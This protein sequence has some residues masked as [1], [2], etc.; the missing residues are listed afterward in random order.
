MGEKYGAIVNGKDYRDNIDY[1]LP[2]C[3]KYLTE[4]HEEYQDH[5]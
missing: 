2:A 5:N 4:L 1:A 3:G